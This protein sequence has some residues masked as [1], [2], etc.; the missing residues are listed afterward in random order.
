VTE[1]ISPEDLRAAGL[2]DAQARAAALFRAV[3]E[4]GIIAPG[5]LDSEATAAVVDL[6]TAQFGVKRH[7]H[8]RIVRSGPHTL[9]PYQENPPDRAM[10]R[11]DIVYADFGPVFDGWEGDF[12]RT[13]VIGTDPDKLRLRDDLAVVFAAGKRSFESHPDITAAEL[14]AEVVRLSEERGWEYGNFHCGH[15]VGEF[16]HENFDGE[17]IESMI[18]PANTL[19]M[20]R[21]DPSG[22]VGHWILEIHLVDRAREIGGFYEELLSL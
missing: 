22:R 2:L 13:W 3:E 12:G 1:A 9:R 20:R 4:A 7:W 8:K 11:D 15:L 5:V 14:Y 10:T 19:P 21:T 16:P 18:T 17:K 6:A